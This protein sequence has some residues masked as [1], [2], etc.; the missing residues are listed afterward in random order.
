VAHV[1][2][3]NP[4]SQLSYTRKTL[5]TVGVAALVVALILII[6]FVA[7]QL[8][9]IFAGVL[10]AVLLRALT[11]I[12]HRYTRIPC[13]VALW[14]VVLG[15][16]GMIVGAS[17]F[18]AAQ[19]SAQFEQLGAGL[20]DAWHRLHDYIAQYGWG[21]TM[22]QQLSQAGLPAGGA[23][24]LGSIVGGTVGALSMLVVS[25]FLG[26]YLAV[27]PNLYR[28]GLLRLLPPKHRKRGGDILH[29]M[30][31]AL[32]GWLLG[33][34]FNMFVIGT[35]VSVGLWLLGI[36]MALALGIIAFFLEFIPYLGPIASAIPAV[37]IA[38]TIGSTEVVYTAL[39]YWG[40]QS[41]EGYLLSP[42]VYQ[43]SVDLPPALTVGAQII[44][45]TL[46]GV[47]GI[48][49]ATPLTACALILVQE[50]YIKDTLGDRI[51]AEPQRA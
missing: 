46:F 41:A 1:A 6:V 29:E 49:F 21:R 9:I 13:G 24:I 25:V 3:D 32:R 43:H 45:A 18:L 11:D 8:L 40:V 50:A 51:Q 4:A 38:S 16:I 28:R 26:L 19:A 33:T 30:A 2:E 44:L 31:I 7:R 34:L 36:P 20:T 15:I 35:V 42:L 23:D 48:V 47:L 37:L 22:I 10:L 12:V 17:W 14:V 27:N 5:V 39:F